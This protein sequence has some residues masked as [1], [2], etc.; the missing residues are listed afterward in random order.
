MF[1]VRN[2][3]GTDVSHAMLNGA[4]RAELAITL[5]TGKVPI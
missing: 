2:L 4:L 5:T 3:A 1:V